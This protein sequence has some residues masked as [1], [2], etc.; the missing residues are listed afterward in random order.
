MKK[1]L[2]GLSLNQMTEFVTQLGEKPYRAKQLMRWIYG[3]GV[4]D[5][6]EM[7]DI[8]HS[9]REKL[10]EVATVSELKQLLRQDSQ[11]GTRKYLFELADGEQ[12]EAVFMPG[13]RRT[14]LCISS[15]VGCGMG[16]T[17]C[18][19]AKMGYQRNLSVGEII[20]Q[21]LYILRD[22]AMLDKRE[23]INVVMMGMGEPLANYDNLIPTLKLMSHDYGL[24]IGQKRITVSTVGLVPRIYQLADEGL[25]VGLAISL[26]SSSNEARSAVIPVNRKYPIEKL[27]AAAKYYTQ[28]TGRRVTFEYVLLAGQNDTIEDAK[29]LVKIVHGVPCKINLIPF[30]PH[31]N[32]GFERPQEDGVTRFREY[33]LPRTY[34]VT[35]RE[36]RGRDIAAACGQLRVEQAV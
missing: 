17:F 16:C 21:A 22:Q 8:S 29:R 5:F 14:T 3:K 1:N 15:Q 30:N 24:Q 12:I 20:D 35:V 10:A 36:N 13:E 31:R 11:D 4:S 7:T 34:A 33:L 2:K 19:T 32:S 23:R 26:N 6:K 25:K 9:F 27:I 18:A 28:Q